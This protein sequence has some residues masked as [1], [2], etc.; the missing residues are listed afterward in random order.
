[1]KLDMIVDMRE[2]EAEI[3]AGYIGRRRHPEF[4]NLATVGYTDRCQFDNHW[5]AT[6]RAC[7]GIIYDSTTLEVLA[8]PFA[9]FFNY[10]QDADAQYDLDAPI[11]GAYNKFDGSLG[12]Q[13]PR[14]DGR[15]GIA[16]R[17]SFDS[18]QARHATALAWRQGGFVLEGDGFTRLYE[19]IFPANRIVIDYGDRDELVYLGAVHIETG[20]YYS[21]ALSMTAG[22][23]LGEVLSLPPRKNAEGYVIWI[24]SRHA[25]K[26]KQ[27]DYLELHR[28]VMSLS[29]KEV[30]R[31]L[32]AGTF[33][34]FAAALP[35]EFHQWARKT[36]SG[37]RD[38]FTE[39]ETQSHLLYER[40]I[41]RGFSDRK[42]QALWLKDHAGSSMG[43]VFSLLD[44]K[45]IADSIWRAIEPSGAVAEI[46]TADLLS[47][48]VL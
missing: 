39:V 23:T 30:W 36:A 4:P 9:K 22:A 12:I 40:V 8:R 26:L 48:G 2:L 15:V 21:P 28:I 10:G 24:N 37:L 16:T 45:D 47:A 32:R 42:S 34:E 14:P 38:T 25:V 29:V 7:R 27:Q 17:G 19:I 20:D 35:D 6:T 1:M 31:Q 18:E 3:A 41:E 43:Y 11:L 13:Y 5:T 44:G 33:D 46:P